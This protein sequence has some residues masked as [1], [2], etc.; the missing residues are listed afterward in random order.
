[1]SASLRLSRPS[2][3][4]L[5]PNEPGAVPARRG[6][7]VQDHVATGYL[8]A[9]NADATLL[10][11]YCEAADDILLFWD[12]DGVLEP[13]FVQVKSDRL[14]QL[15]T[16][17]RFCARANGEVSII[18][19]SLSR[20]RFQ[21][22][23]RFRIVI[24]RDLDPPLEPFSRDLNHASRAATC[25]V[26]VDTLK[27]LTGKL[28][29]IQSESGA[30]LEHWLARTVFEVVHSE[31]VVRLRNLSQLERVLEGNSWN[32]G[33]DQKDVVYEHLARVAKD[34]ADAD[35]AAHPEAKKLDRDTIV[36]LLSDAVEDVKNTRPNIPLETTLKSAGLSSQ[37][38]LGAREATVSFESARR[39]RKF[40]GD[41]DWEK[42]EQTIAGELHRLWSEYEAGGLNDSPLEFHARCIQALTEL[43]SRLGIELQTGILYGALYSRVKRGL[44]RFDRPSLREVA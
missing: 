33:F 27:Y 37:T 4:D 38:I 21:E 17:A 43:H 11:V 12:R 29:A 26:F 8:I 42:L 34:A 18:E 16:I 9:M 19:R 30:T 3:R 40:Y 15:W 13:E 32:L 28:G 35:G 24:T 1:M 2:I 41:E 23:C 5:V 25:T 36:R 22:L 14:T 6:F 7:R 31:E 44:L 20:D 10:A 39:D